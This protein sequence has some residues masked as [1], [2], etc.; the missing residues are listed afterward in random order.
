MFCFVFAAN[1]LHF[2]E[3][4]NFLGGIQWKTSWPITSDS[5]RQ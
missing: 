2:F 1:D 3:I 4:V 5:T